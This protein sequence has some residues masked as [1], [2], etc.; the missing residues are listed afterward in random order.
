M[1]CFLLYSRLVTSLP[2]S[3]VTA[4]PG[5]MAA[6]QRGGPPDWTHHLEQEV[7]HA[8]RGWLTLGSKSKQ[9]TVPIYYTTT[10]TMEVI[11]LHS[12]QFIMEAGDVKVK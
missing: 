5:F 10:T 11:C 3:L 2:A 12:L 6:I 9:G 4:A 8:P 1:S 7:S